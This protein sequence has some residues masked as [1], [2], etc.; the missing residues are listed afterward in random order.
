MSK[1]VVL[2]INFRDQISKIVQQAIEHGLMEH[3]KR[4]TERLMTNLNKRSL[5][6]QMD[7]Q[8]ILNFSDLKFVL[9]IYLLGMLFSFTVFFIELCFNS[10]K[11]VLINFLR[12]LITNLEYLQQYVFK[13]IFLLTQYV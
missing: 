2:N 3:F 10:A 5:D 13:K 4:K 7:A 12:C 9:I 6:L 8:S 1:F 11:K